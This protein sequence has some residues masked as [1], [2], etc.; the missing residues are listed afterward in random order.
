MLFTDIEGSTRLQLE[1]VDEYARLLAAHKSIVRDALALH[2]GMEIDT[3]GD[4]FF[5][6]FARVPSAIAAAAT[7]QTQLTGPVRVR[8]GIHTGE[9][10]WTGDGYVGSDV[11][12][13]ARICTAAHGGQV[14]LSAASLEL[15]A[16]TP[17]TPLG[18]HRLKDIPEPIE[19]Y[20]LG[21][22]SFPPLRTMHATN[23]PGQPILIGRE[24]LLADLGLLLDAG[25]TRLITV[26]GPGGIGKTSLASAAA[27]ERVASTAAGVFFVDLTR[28]REPA[29]VVGTIAET[30]GATGD[31]A[32]YI[33]A[34][35][36]LLVLDNME[37]VI[38]AAPDV[39]G[40][41]ARCPNLTAIVT[42][43]I[44]LRVRGER[45][46]PVGTLPEDASVA[47]F[48]ERARS[49]DP[50]LASDQTVIEICRRLDGLPLAIELAASRIAVLSPS[51]LLDRLDQRLALLTGGPRDVA[52]RQQTLRATVAWSV[53]LL[54]PGPRSLFA[55]L[56]VFVGGWTLGAAEAICDASLDG[57]EV[58]IEHNLVHRTGS[59]YGMLETIR[60]F[61]AEEFEAI[62]EGEAWRDRQAAHFARLAAESADALEGPDQG[63]WRRRLTQELPNLRAA[64]D[65]MDR[66][67]PDRLLP[68]ATDL[69]RFWDMAGLTQEGRTWIERGLPRFTGPDSVRAVAL[70]RLGILAEHQG[71][72]GDAAKTYRTL[73][74]LQ[75][76]MGDRAGLADTERGM[77]GVAAVR[78]RHRDAHRLLDKAIAI[79]R[80]DGDVRRT[81][82]GLAQLALLELDYGDPQAAMTDALEMEEAYRAVGDT[83]GV[84]AA[85]HHQANA[86]RRSGHLA[87]AEARAARALHIFE[88][89]DNSTW[90]PYVLLNL[91]WIQLALEKIPTARANLC[92]ALSLA[93]EHGTAVAVPG[94]LDAMGAVAAAQGDPSLADRIVRASDELS[95]RGR[96]PRSP[97]DSRELHR[98]IPRH[99]KPALA[100]D[101]VEPDLLVQELVDTCQ[102]NAAAPR[103]LPSASKAQ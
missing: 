27:A 79:H 39:A 23:V 50:G 53:D 8:M 1:G 52:D 51:E 48:L 68:F 28:V 65:W 15:D 70:R 13:A 2:D 103:H 45:A 54:P 88:D 98:Y 96:W 12:M 75:R 25:G 43:R 84:A 30:I 34:K 38:D 59:R 67:S 40:L 89:A 90:L 56:A 83:T 26:V 17:V 74:A 44:R 57:L 19:L 85:I 100:G 69:A 4:A 63:A 101:A 7:I 99:R 29:L 66:T 91:G 42:S 102:V 3:Q 62:P 10:L 6:I 49:T 16:S 80:E 60:E 24:Q 5:A 77:A 37:H 97:A 55:R 58:L 20:Q 35:A 47:L 92:R 87:E 33:G 78:G 46:F 86:L 9:G 41:L 93:T 32:E 76:R 11:H 36:M 81:A 94:I 14:L 71:D 82:D 22:E 95:R 18:L 72:L 73:S 21:T 61:A 64:L 31:L